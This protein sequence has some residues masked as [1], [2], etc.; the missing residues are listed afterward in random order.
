MS[1]PYSR[2][3]EQITPS[4]KTNAVQI[5]VFEKRRKSDDK[6][7]STTVIKTGGGSVP[8]LTRRCWDQVNQKVR[9]RARR[10]RRRKIGSHY[11]WV[12]IQLRDVLTGLPLWRTIDGETLPVVRRKKI[13]VSDFA[14]NDSGSNGA[15]S[16]DKGYRDGGPFLTVRVERPDFL[17]KGQ[18]TYKTVPEDS[19]P[20]FYYLYKGGFSDPE[21]GGTDLVSDLDYKKVGLLPGPTAGFL[22][23]LDDIGS[24]AYSR[25]RPQLE[26]A[27]LMV[28]L[29][30]AKDI[31]QMLKTTASAFQS[32][33]R[34][35][36]G[37]G[38][39]QILHP[40]SVADHF[41][42]HH[43]GWVPFVSDIQKFH[44][45]F[46][47]SEK[48]IEQISR[49]NN[50]WT[51]RVR[52]MENTEKETLVSKGGIT[53]ACSPWIGGFP[54]NMCRNQTVPG[55]GSTMA[56]WTIS[57]Q[58]KTRVW[59]MGSFKYYRPE[60]DANL[61]DYSSQWNDLQRRLTILGARIS[62]SNVWKSTPWTWLIDWFSNIG[63][64]IDLV[65]DIALD[66]V[67]SRYMYVMRQATRNFVL[68]TSMY[69]WQATINLE[70]SRYV[71][72]KQRQRA[73]TPYGF[74]LFGR[75]LSAKQWAILGALGL[76]RQASLR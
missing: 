63:D 68:R 73:W 62:P 3:R 58:L 61:A 54:W 12:D 45:V 21:F 71:E 14:L 40:K 1:S 13:K 48:Y 36:G 19:D 65:N 66:G 9:L 39:S 6:V 47:N 57:E 23:S 56:N 46:Q 49:D 52:V 70:W 17:V 33:Y 25:L 50:R 35:M 64:H 41:L 60:F 67:V 7:V 16:S 28:A 30:E 38:S 5:G 8:S 27:G 15:S 59:A 2:L 51:K 11:V 26:K 53:G 10:P 44:D 37:S 76:S 4:P 20:S 22:P 69:Y 55:I 74:N 34:G 75:D 43:F 31:P 42:N 24:Q 32:I 72:T 29:R 18:G